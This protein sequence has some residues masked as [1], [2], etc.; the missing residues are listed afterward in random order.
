MNTQY[1]LLTIKETAKLLR[2]SLSSAYALAA[3]GKL[4]VVR[5]G[6]NNGSIRIRA[7]EV[8]R[9]LATCETFLVVKTHPARSVSTA[10]PLTLKHLK[11]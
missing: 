3:S 2:I 8:E 1:S 4:R 7:S 6:S 11:V 10:K 9:Y 5:I